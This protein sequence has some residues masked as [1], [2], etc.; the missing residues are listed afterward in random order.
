MINPSAVS[1]VV[2]RI[3]ILGVLCCWTIINEAAT[4]G[5]GFFRIQGATNTAITGFTS[6]GLLTW[7]NAAVS[8]DCTVEWL[9][10]LGVSNV[11][12]PFVNYPV[13]SPVCQVQ[14]FVPTWPA[15]T[16]MSFLVTT[17]FQMGNCMDTNEG[18]ADELPLHN[19][20]VNPFFMDQVEVYK[21]LWDDVYGWA[22]NHGYGFDNVGFG[23]GPEY[24]VES[25]N[26]YD[27]VKWCNA[28]SEKESLTPAYNTYEYILDEFGDP[29]GTNIVVYRDGSMDITSAQVNWVADGYRLPTEAEWELAA[30]GGKAGNRFPW[31]ETDTITQTNANYY[32]SWDGGVPY[33][34][35]DVNEVEGS[36]FGIFFGV[37][38]FTSPV[39][40]FSPNAYGLYDM[41]GNVSEWCWDW[42]GFA[43]YATGDASDTK[44]PDTDSGSGRVVRG[45]S[46]ESGAFEARCSARS[47][48]GAGGSLSGVGFRCVR[49][50]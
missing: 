35:Y 50:R 1:N 34:P 12:Q 2:K 27:A 39:G 4:S 29:I 7:T 38:H 13:I 44:G 42:Y 9:G 28:R 17:R 23:K 18:Y 8:N 19:V 25:V 45:G 47:A 43:F 14:V 37:D 32:S 36:P 15:P 3:S 40:D 33:Y 30:R 21:A 11:W 22:T 5:Q 48:I 6:S 16:G 31:T 41:A 24:P 10:S 46:G 49:G 20:Y 26:W